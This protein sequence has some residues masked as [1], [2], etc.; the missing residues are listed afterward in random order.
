M[1]NTTLKLRVSIRVFG[2]CFCMRRQ[3]KRK[4]K[5]TQHEI[6]L[7]LANTNTKVLS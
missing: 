1:S 3:G 2:L 5:M 4:H 6:I 7:F